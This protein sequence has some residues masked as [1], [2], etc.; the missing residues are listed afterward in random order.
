M[1]VPRYDPQSLVSRPVLHRAVV[2]IREQSKDG[3]SVSIHSARPPLLQRAMLSSLR[4]AAARAAQAAPSTASAAAAA[5]AAATNVNAAAAAASSSAAAAAAAA[6]SSSIR[7]FSTAAAANS[8]A[9]LLTPEELATRRLAA[10][11]TR[12]EGEARAAKHGTARQRALAKKNQERQ[13]LVEQIH[14]K[15]GLPSPFATPAPQPKLKGKAA[16]RAMRDAHISD[17]TAPASPKVL[18]FASAQLLQRQRARLRFSP[19]KYGPGAP[20]YPKAGA[21]GQVMNRSFKGIFA[22][23]HVHFGNMVSHS[24]RRFV[25]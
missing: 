2:T 6:S 3:R 17:R 16:L 23:R 10:A 25:A 13:A 22:G 20:H 8:T 12:A 24:T 19:L 15:A 4:R 14:K 21:R 1:L 18:P 11:Q 9:P 5:S 7:C